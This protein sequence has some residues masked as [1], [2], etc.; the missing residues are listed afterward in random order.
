MLWAVLV[1]EVPLASTVLAFV[2][3]MSLI[4]ENESLI[5]NEMSC[6]CFIMVLL[7]VHLYTPDRGFYLY[8]FG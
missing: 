6:Y 8:L 7:S 4:L 5:A 1:F 2:M 3:R